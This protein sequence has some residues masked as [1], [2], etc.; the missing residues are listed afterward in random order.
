MKETDS[1]QQHNSLIHVVLRLRGGGPGPTEL[2][3]A[4]GG[5]ITQSIVSLDR[6]DY[7]KSVPVTFNVQIL[8][9]VSFKQV[10][11]KRPPKSP[12]T[13]KTYA[14]CGYPF[15]FMWEEPTTVSGDFSKIRS[16][17]QIDNNPDESLSN[18][19]VVD[20]KTREFIHDWICE[21]C[22][23]KNNA[24]GQRCG[25]CF[26]HRPEPEVAG[27]VGIL[28]PGGPHEPLK[29]EWEMEDEIRQMRTAF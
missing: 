20:V 8:D 7:P 9:I 15:S 5:R 6:R 3:I 28:N 14:D 4:A 10:T 23:T 29:L 17:A 27:K 18:I 19:P 1:L 21:R 16:V 25:G 11:G 12:V 22:N 2:S 26:T 13:A 24:A